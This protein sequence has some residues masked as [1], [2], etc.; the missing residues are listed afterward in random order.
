MH[1]T[2]L[3]IA[4]LALF[5]P[6]S[7]GGQTYSTGA[8]NIYSTCGLNPDLSNRIE[9]AKRFRDWYNLA[10]FPIVSRWENN[11]VFNTDFTDGPGKD[12]DPGG[13]SDAP[14]IYLFA[15]HGS[16]QNPYQGRTIQILSSHAAMAPACSPTSAHPH[17]GVT[18]VVT[19][20]LLSS[21]RAAP[22]TSFR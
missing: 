13:G 12:M 10:H 11:D 8:V 9:A 21:T 14:N 22:W 3:A 19:C 1:K 20:S 6:S 18:P 15:G 7:V 2:W 17:D 5:V 16:C 4:M